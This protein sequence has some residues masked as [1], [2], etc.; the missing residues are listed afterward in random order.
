MLS[1]NNQTP[2][3]PSK[4]FNPAR[5]AN[6]PDHRAGDSYLALL[7]KELKRALSPEL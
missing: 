2:L 3:D 7:D 4:Q 6:K 1:D 5:P